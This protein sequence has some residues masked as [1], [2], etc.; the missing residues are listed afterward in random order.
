[1]LSFDPLSSIIL[2]V[3][4]VAVSLRLRAPFLTRGR[5]SAIGVFVTLIILLLPISVAACCGLFLDLGNA[6]GYGLRGYVYGLWGLACGHEQVGDIG[7]GVTF[8]H[9]LSKC[10]VID[11]YDMEFEN[12]GK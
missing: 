8:S 10:C 2:I 9:R 4:G 7:S 12:V 6:M 3:L 11:L 5:S 1:M